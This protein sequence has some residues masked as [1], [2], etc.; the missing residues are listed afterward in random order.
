MPLYFNTTG[1]RFTGHHYMVP[2]LHRL[3]GVNRLIEQGQ[4]FVIHA[5][6][7]S[8]KTTY[9]FALM[10]KLNRWL[11]LDIRKQ[12]SIKCGVLSKIS[13]TRVGSGTPS[14]TRQERYSLMFWDRGKMRS[15]VN[16]RN[17]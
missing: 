8:G 14:I 13:R 3:K 7:Q 10:E 15:S 17:D 4:Y 16:S 12:N 6:R 11:S 1:P 5:P 9:S 2:P